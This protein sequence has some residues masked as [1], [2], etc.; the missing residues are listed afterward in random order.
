VPTWTVWAWLVISA[1]WLVLYVTGGRVLDLVLAVLGLLMGVIKGR[2]WY[3][4]R[5]RRAA[6][7]ADH[8]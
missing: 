6:L 5:E 7:R 4:Q 3:A 1:A 2:E 8:R